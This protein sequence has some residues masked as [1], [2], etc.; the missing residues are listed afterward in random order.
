MIDITEIAK[1][2][3]VARIA[4]WKDRH[5]ITLANVSR[6]AKA[7]HRSK[8]WIK[9]DILT[10]ETGKG[11]H[12]DGYIADKYALIEAVKALGGSVREG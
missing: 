10:T 8:L 11:Y 6:S 7:D 2:S 1:L 4:P 5:Y 9:G 12:S 3:C